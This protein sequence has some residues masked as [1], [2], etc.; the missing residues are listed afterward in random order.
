MNHREL[1]L[2]ARKKARFAFL[3][4]PEDLQDEVIEGLDGQTL[5]LE[6][7]STL[8]K[9]RGHSLS[10]VAISGYYRA[11]RMERR[12]LDS[13]QEL[14]RVITE[15]A[16]KPQREALEGLVNLTIAITA[17]GLVDGSVGIADIDLPK[18]V[19]AMHPGTGPSPEK[20]AESGKSTGLTPETADKIRREILGLK[21]K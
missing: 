4:L 10:Y 1:I 21:G 3:S 6:A 20:A 13:R 15:F 7:A 8:V 17:S 11:L 19:K 12:L 14:S 5:T 16:G 2:S 18:L 9:A